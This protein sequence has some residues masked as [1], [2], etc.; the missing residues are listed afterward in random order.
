MVAR[1]PFWNAHAGRRQL[2]AMT[3][4]VIGGAALGP[5]NA[6]N[7]H[8][9]E[10]GFGQQYDTGGTTSVGF[11]AGHQLVE[12]HQSQAAST[13]WYS[14][15]YTYRAGVYWNSPG[16]QYDNG[17]TPKCALNDNGIVVEV[18][19]SQSNSGLWYHVGTLGGTRVNWGGSSNYD[20][21]ENPAVAVNDAGTVVEVHKSQSANTLWYHVGA[22]SG[23]SVN[24]GG[25][26]NYD[27]GGYTP[28]V[29]LNNSG[30]VVE[31][32]QSSSASTLW[33]RVGS[34][35]GTTINWGTS[36]Y[37]TDGV[38]PSIALTDD[39][40]VV[41]THASGSGAVWQNTGYISGT[42]IVWNSVP[43]QFDSGVN[44]AVAVSGNLAVQTTQYSNNA[45][46]SSSSLALDRASWMENAL[47]TLGNLALSQI[48]VPGSHDA[49][50][51][52]NTII[53]DLAQ[54]QDL[55]IQQQLYAGV[56][57]F[58]LRPHWTGSDLEIYHG[59]LYAES[60]QTVLNDVASFMQTNRRE[61]VILKFSHYDNFDSAGVA[62][63]TLTS[64]IQA[65][66]GSWLYTTRP[67]GARLA[68]LTLNQYVAGGGKVLVVSD[69][70]EP[71]DYPSTGVYVYRDWNSSDPQNGDLVV[72]DQYAD[73]TDYSTMKSD[74]FTK[75]DDFTGFAQNNSSVP[76]D[77]F[78]LSWT[79][80]P[81]VDVW[82]VVGTPDQDLGSAINTLSIPNSSGKM[83]NIVYTDYVEYS[84]STDVAE[85]LNGI[86]N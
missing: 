68:S 17:I 45:L 59:P 42:S 54:T 86:P 29:A 13:L 18:H 75:F 20:S 15:G 41:E 32:H 72:F 14:V 74:Q 34:V 82:S 66:I 67:A 26:V 61:L 76:C 36:T 84:R 21:G 81:A 3:L 39:G 79:L 6:S 37:Y 35:S 28:A 56:R 51:Y 22:V 5:A 43:S 63:Q 16:I 11:N 73:V 53:Y 69:G 25:S 31:V 62:Y 10:F 19:Q 71:L 38:N 57:Y 65:T 80:T 64:W 4:W 30:T 44:T 46:A 2:I 83:V 70:S 33:Y 60:V 55:T 48:A 78:L 58:D 49:G 77:L 9:V 50:M 1:N 8:N 85:Y 7:I 52:Y 40:Q 47:P 12:V 24:F 27:G 23:S